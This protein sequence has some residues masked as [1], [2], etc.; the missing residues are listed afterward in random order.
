MGFLLVKFRRGIPI[1]RLQESFRHVSFVRLHGDWHAWRL[2][3]ANEIRRHLELP[4][5]TA[6]LRSTLDDRERCGR[7]ERIVIT[8]STSKCLTGQL[9][10]T[11]LLVS[12]ESVSPE[13]ILE[14]PNLQALMSFLR[15]LDEDPTIEVG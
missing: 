10:T 2:N 13:M 15:D 8:L 11:G 3:R 1:D 9:R 7:S 5:D 4:E 14:D 6:P 12:N